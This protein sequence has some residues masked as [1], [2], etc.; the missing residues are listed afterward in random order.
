ME[1]GGQL[2]ALARS[3]AEQLTVSLEVGRRASLCGPCAAA[4]RSLSPTAAAAAAAV[5]AALGGRRD[6]L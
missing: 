5:Q 1:G 3:A 2:S 4:A 6:V